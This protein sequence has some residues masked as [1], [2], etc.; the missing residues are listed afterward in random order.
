MDGMTTC[1]GR[2]VVQERFSTG[3]EWN[4]PEQETLI[5]LDLRDAFLADRAEEFAADFTNRWAL[6]DENATAHTIVDLV[7]GLHRWN[8]AQGARAARRGR[9]RLRWAADPALLVI[10]V[11]DEHPGPFRNVA[12]KHAESEY[13]YFALALLRPRSG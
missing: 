2:I 3:F 1:T 7:A 6:H 8:T 10:E 5:V 9:L 13:R 4:G 12:S 11:W